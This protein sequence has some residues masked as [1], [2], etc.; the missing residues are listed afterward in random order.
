MCVHPTAPTEAWLSRCIAAKYRYV[1]NSRATGCSDYS[2]SS[3]LWHLSEPDMDSTAK[4]APAPA[5]M[6]HEAPC[7]TV[8]IQK[9]V[10]RP[11][12]GALLAHTNNV[13]H[14]NYDV[15]VD[16]W[17][18]TNGRSVQTPK[19]SVALWTIG[20]TGHTADK[21][22]GRRHRAH[23]HTPALCPYLLLKTHGHG[24]HDIQQTG[25][26]EVDTPC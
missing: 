22:E 6:L 24:M 14:P 5:G 8:A 25:T 1:Y 18:V 20:N 17:T 10:P 16:S 21:K 7:H 12:A 9:I 13:P 11:T 26:H 23:K 2:D 15:I 19:D 4:G 3:A